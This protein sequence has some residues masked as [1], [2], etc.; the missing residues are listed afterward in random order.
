[1]SDDLQDF[2]EHDPQIFME[3]LQAKG[4][5]RECPCCG[6]GSKWYAPEDGLVRIAGTVSEEGIQRRVKMSMECAPVVCGNC[7]FVRFHL[8]SLPLG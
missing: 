6:D 5:L 2:E 3:G 1:V 8:L 4:A 7:D